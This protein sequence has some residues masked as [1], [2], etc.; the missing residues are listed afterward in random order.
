M[1]R[2][3]CLRA[4]CRGLLY[5]LLTLTLPVT[6]VIAQPGHNNGQGGR[7]DNPGQQRKQE[8]RD[9]SKREQRD[10]Y[11]HQERDNYKQRDSGKKTSAEQAAR[12]AQQRYGGRV[13]K[14]DPR[15]SGYSVRLLQDDGRVITVVIGE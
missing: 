8:Q 12:Q 15:G 14:V 10:N 7:D 11:T 6:G 5:A 1:H 13:L 3:A 2:Q 9:H 4:L